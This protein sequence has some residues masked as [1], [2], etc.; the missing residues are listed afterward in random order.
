MPKNPG[1]NTVIFNYP[2]VVN[3]RLHKVQSQPPLTFTQTGCN[4]QTV[5]VRDHIDNTAYS[6][7][8]NKCISPSNDN[9]NSVVAEWLCTFN[10]DV[11]RILGANAMYDQWG[12][13][14]YVTFYCKTETPT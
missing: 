9:T 2:G 11:Y 3:D 4:M 12:R 6:Q 14:P 5:T 13:I 8:T 7:A 1:N 10:N